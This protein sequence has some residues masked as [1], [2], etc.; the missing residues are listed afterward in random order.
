MSGVRLF[1]PTARAG[2]F[3]FEHMDRPLG[4]FNPVLKR[5]DPEPQWCPQCQRMHP[6][7]TYH[8]T[9]DS[10]GFAFVSIEIWEKMKAK[11][12]AG[13]RLANEVDKPPAQSIAVGAPAL[14]PTAPPPKE[15]VHSG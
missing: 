6:V 14:I 3:T 5:H 1:H 11:G 4:R 10:E 7:K 9:V 15:I 8:V 13:F 12:T 2:V